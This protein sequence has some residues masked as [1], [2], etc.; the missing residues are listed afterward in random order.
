MRNREKNTRRTADRQT[1]TQNQHVKLNNHLDFV[2]QLIQN[3]FYLHTRTHIHTY[4][5]IRAYTLHTITLTWYVLWRQKNGFVNCNDRCKLISV[6]FNPV[7]EATDTL[8]F[9]FTCAIRCRIVAYIHSRCVCV[10]VFGVGIVRLEMNNTIF[11]SH[12][13]SFYLPIRTLLHSLVHSFTHLY[14]FIWSHVKNF[15]ST[16]IK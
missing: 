1:H 4:V 15:A 8:Y 2:A 6:K 16:P 7:C 5:C 10:C 3:L 13:H 11:Y 12:C 14:T 9:I